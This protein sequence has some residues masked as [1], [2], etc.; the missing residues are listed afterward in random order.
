MSTRKL[1]LWQTI[2]PSKIFYSAIWGIIIGIVISLTFNLVIFDN[3]FW[4][5]SA[6][7]IFLVR[8]TSRFL[9]HADYCVNY[10][11]HNW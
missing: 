4:L 5:I 3:I 9:P 11:Y 10:W 7:L 1:F 8:L 2:H 6:L